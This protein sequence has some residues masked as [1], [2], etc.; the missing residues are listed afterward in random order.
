MKK[1]LLEANLEDV[2]MINCHATSTKVGDLSEVRAIGNSKATLVGN[3]SQLGHTFGAAGAIE[4]IFT[5]LSVKEDIIPA[6]LN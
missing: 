2:D 3:K 6:T 5:V 1:A 4:S